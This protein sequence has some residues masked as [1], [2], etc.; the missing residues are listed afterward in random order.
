[1]YKIKVSTELNELLDKI[2]KKRDVI[3][4]Y[5]KMMEECGELTQALAKHC[6]EYP[7][8][9]TKKNVIEECADV[10]LMAIHL[11][12]L[13]GESHVDSIAKKKL[14]KLSND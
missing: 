1:M 13:I 4:I 3:N 14:I 12:K 2:E 8:K 7:S 6:T 10:L 9:K 11:R 5:L